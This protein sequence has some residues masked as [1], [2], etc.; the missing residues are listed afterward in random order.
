MSVVFRATRQSDE[1]TVA[2]KIFTAG[3]GSNAALLVHKFVQEARLLALIDHP[4]LVKFYNAGHSSI[5]VSPTN[6]LTLYTKPHSHGR[7]G[8]T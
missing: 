6:R 1:Q 5:A 7:I 2:I 3:T 8:F 4:H